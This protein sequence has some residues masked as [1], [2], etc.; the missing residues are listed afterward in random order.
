VITVKD[1]IEYLK[2]FPENTPLVVRKDEGAVTRWYPV[3]TTWPSYVDLQKQES[4]LYGARYV[5]M[6]DRDYDNGTNPI[7]ALEI[8]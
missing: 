2:Q 3:D 4:P 7:T 5:E 1:Y 8:A 6:R